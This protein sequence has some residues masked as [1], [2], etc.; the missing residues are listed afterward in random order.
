MRA[1]HLQFEFRKF[2]IQS[3][4]PMLTIL[5]GVLYLFC[6]LCLADEEALPTCA[7][8]S[9]ASTPHHLL[10]L[11]QADEL[12]TNEGSSQNHLQHKINK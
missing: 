11:A 7:Q 12:A 4:V 9:S 10:V 1:L 6:I 8:T 3:N 5:F 2:R